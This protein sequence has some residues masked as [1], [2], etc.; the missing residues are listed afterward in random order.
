MRRNGEIDN[1]EDGAIKATARAPFPY[2]PLS[3]FLRF[4]L[5]FYSPHSALVLLIT[6][7]KR[8]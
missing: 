2:F 7:A 6:G 5:P 4:S 3:P 8:N 1:S